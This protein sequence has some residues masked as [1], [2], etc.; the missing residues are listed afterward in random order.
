MLTNVIYFPLKEEKDLIK[1]F[2]DDYRE[3][4]RHVPAWIPRLMPWKGENE[5]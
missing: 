2:G 3:Y 1:R 4:R 5:S